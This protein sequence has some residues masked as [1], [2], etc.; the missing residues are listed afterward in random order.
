MALTSMSVM[1]TVMVLNLHHRGP[2]KQAVPWWLKDLLI[3]KLSPFLCLQD[4]VTSATNGYYNSE[5]RFIKNMSLKITLDNIQ[6]ALENE[7]KLDNRP[8]MTNSFNNATSDDTS[9][10]TDSGGVK[11]TA[12][13]EGSANQGQFQQHRSVRNDH[14]SSHTE[15]PG[16][17]SSDSKTGLNHQNEVQYHSS[18]NYQHCPRSSQHIYPSIIDKSYRSS[19][20]LSPSK[21]EKD[22]KTKRRHQNAA[23]SKTNEEILNSL[24]R[25][26]EKHE[27]EDRDYEVVQEWRRVAQ[28][29]DRILFFIF[30]IATFTS[31][32]AILVI[33]PLAQ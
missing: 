26:L 27:K 29:V 15:P 24:K 23:L 14:L 16:V 28:C 22:K 12:N 6:Q 8:N 9:K 4:S 2:S 21:H 25:I 19:N 30:L 11:G 20:S 13:C 33:A 5:E 32:V 31:T 7:I 1:M 3:N 17:Q 18:S 10:V